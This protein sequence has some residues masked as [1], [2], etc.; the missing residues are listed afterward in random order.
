MKQ[1]KKNILRVLFLVAILQLLS[2][3]KFVDIEPAPNLINTDA[4]FAT[5]ATAVASM[6][7]VYIKMRSF[8]LALTNGGLSVFAGLSA[9]EIY[10]TS[11]STTYDPFFRDS[12]PVDNNT[13][14]RNFWTEPYGNIYRV[15]AVIEGLARSRT[16]TD[17]L[18]KQLL[19]E[20]KF[21]RGLY[22]F[23]LVNLFGDVPLITETEYETN[24]SMGRTPVHQIYQFLEKDLTEAEALLSSAYRSQGRITANKW[25][26]AALLARIYLFQKNWSLAEKKANEVLMSG[27]YQ[28]VNNIN[29]VF[30]KT[31]PETILEIAPQN[32][33]GNTVEG[34]TFIPASATTRPSLALTASLL[35]SFEGA[36][37][38]KTSWTK[39]TTVGGIPYVYPLKYKV[40]SGASIAE[41]NIVLRLA[42]QYLIRAEARAHIGKLTEAKA[43]I[44]AIRSR[45][46]LSGTSANDQ[47]SLLL[48]I[49]SERRKELFCE[50]GHRWF[51]LKRT[52]R[53]DAVLSAVKPFWKDFAAYY[54]IPF[55]QIQLNPFLT[56]N[57]G[58]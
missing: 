2:C 20:A 28:L 5:D 45:A 10:N 40:R 16:L 21:V 48:A 8:S 19:G 54:P 41:Y 4:V 39:S 3:K 56:Q 7:G 42:E 22:Y 32:E 13:L 35:N 46:G 14:L 9:D 11:T 26:V 18:K 37:Q 38:R 57:P 1:L 47:Q 31:S 23:Y 12:I 24:Q 33:S 50:W 30:L 15:N 34:A 51:D 36:D 43:D 49:E 55:S 6:N 17:T 29:N 52:D 44:D 25:A 58:Y 27:A 53:I